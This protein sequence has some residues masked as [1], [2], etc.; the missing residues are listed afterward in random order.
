MLPSLGLPQALF[1]SLPP[2][3]NAPRGL[4]SMVL[5]SEGLVPVASLYLVSSGTRVPG[6]H[7]VPH[8]VFA[9]LLA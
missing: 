9:C 4:S 5:P 8:L 6:V 2:V 1:T 7:A 3:E